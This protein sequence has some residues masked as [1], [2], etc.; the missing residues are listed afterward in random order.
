MA[1]LWV[2]KGGAL[3]S[4]SCSRGETAVAVRRLFGLMVLFAFS[5]GM[6]GV[7]WTQA[8][9]NVDA[10]NREVEKF[11]RDGN[12]TAA[13]TVAQWAS[14][15]AEA[16]FGS[17][18]PTVA[19]TLTNLALVYTRMGRYAEA[20][21][22][23][24]RSLEIDEAALGPKH[25]SVATTL[26]N[27][28]LLYARQG[29]YADAEPLYK[30]SLAIDRVVLEPNHPSVATTLNNL[31]GLYEAQGR[32]AEAEPLYRRSL[33]IDESALGPNHPSLATTL[34]NLAG[35][36]ITQERYA[37]AE[38]LLRRSLTIT[39]VGLGSE[40]PSVAKILNHLAR[41]ALSQR[42][43]VQAMERWKRATAILQRRAERR[44]G[45]TAKAKR[46]GETQQ[47]KRSFEGLIK[48]MYR[49]AGAERANA[50]QLANESF[51]TA[52][53]I[54]ASGAA[55]SLAQVAARSAT[56]S[57][58]L[59]A[60][61][62]NRNDLVAEWEASDRLLIAAR[63]EL[64]AQ[65]RAGR[66]KAFRNRV[67]TID[68]HLTEIDARLAKD[69][70]E[71]AALS[72]IRP[73]PVADVQAQ[74][75]DNEALVLFLDTDDR[76]KPLAEET[77]VWVITKSDVRWLRSKYGTARLRREVAALRCGLDAMAW[78]GDS[79]RRCTNLVKPPLDKVP[80]PGEAPQF[81]I[82]RAHALYSHL[83]GG[84]EDLV[85]D[86]HLLVVPSGALTKLPFH[87]LVTALPDGVSAGPVTAAQ[88]RG[89]RWLARNH[90]IT[91]LPSVAALKSLR[92]LAKPSLAD[93]SMIGFGNPLLDGPDARFALLARLARNSQKF[94]GTVLKRLAALFGAR[95]GIQAV[96]PPGGLADLAH[97]KAQVPLPGTADELCS[98]AREV[99]A[100]LNHIYLGVRATETTIKQ[101]S[102]SGELGRYRIIH[103]ATHSILAGQLSDTFEPGLILT[104]PQT[105]TAEDDGYL[106]VSE[107]ANLKLDADWVILSARNTAGFADDTNAEALSGLAQVFFYAGA[108]ALLVSHWEVSSDVKV[109]LITSVVRALTEDNAVGR[110]EALR[111]AMVGLIDNGTMVEAHPAYWA[112]F[113]VVGEGAAG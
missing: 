57:P 85:R 55:A 58:D 94:P 70:P 40:H 59:T 8:S 79:A 111:R 53:W 83:L 30:R 47:H 23:Y 4:Q 78:L 46:K 104:P 100:D 74:L 13:L 20:E 29:R 34:N 3:G 63:A 71:Y 82:A 27:L 84:A 77:F 35:L 73:I 31:A 15:L 16:K 87:V 112:P 61:V 64:G 97:L 24:K 93:R 11:F 5:L 6:S 90:A 69:F 65:R 51:E 66:E 68:R 99:G 102:D 101:L 91:V 76:F 26:N 88:E 75:R 86:K 72:G 43:W 1:S 2:A 14:V 62:R 105:T 28:A 36:Y 45:A 92:R 109:R 107:I 106:S 89:V 32:H 7:S 67:S 19:M 10:L 108:R 56:G 33:E 21:P 96:G 22:L 49:V 44:L 48:A 37:E 113:V 52:Q 18:H 17:N 95:G 38:P 25:P 60:L 80:Q 110:A 9:D 50:E 39:E 54:W 98:V 41:V 42:K 103:F 12:Y 81:D